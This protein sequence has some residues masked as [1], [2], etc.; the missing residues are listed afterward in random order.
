MTT[1]STKGVSSLITFNKGAV[2]QTR[3]IEVVLSVTLE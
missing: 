3:H 1:P 2:D